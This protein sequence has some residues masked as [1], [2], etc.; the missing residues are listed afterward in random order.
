MIDG[1]ADID[2]WTRNVA[3]RRNSFWLPTRTDK[4]YPDFVAKPKDG[5]TL[6]V[7]YK[8]K[9]LAGEQITQDT[10]EKQ[11]IGDVWASKSAGQGVFVLATMEDG[12]PLEV[13]NAILRALKK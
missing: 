9:H 2:Y 5:R 8:G 11:A 10:R 6:V 3:R 7:E 13:R 4:F 12:N 1:L